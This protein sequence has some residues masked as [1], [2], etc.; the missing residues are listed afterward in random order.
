KMRL[1]GLDE[2][3]LRQFVS[4][5]SG[6][7]WEEFYEALFGYEAKLQARDKWGRGER[8]RLRKTFGAWRDPVVRWID[9]KQQSRRGAREKKLLQ[10]IEEKSLE[11]KGVNLMT[12]RRQAQRAAEAMVTMAAEIKEAEKV[13]AAVRGERLAIGR[14]LKDAAEKPE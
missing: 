14:A 1:H 12:A 8:G 13:P 10:K 9:A 5:Y 2:E 11:A 4:K 6:E 3:A 7:R